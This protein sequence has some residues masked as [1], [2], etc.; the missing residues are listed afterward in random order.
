ME[1]CFNSFVR[2]NV[3]VPGDYRYR[4]FG[5]VPSGS[6]WTSLVGTV[7]NM[8]ML[9]L[10]S[11]EILREKGFDLR[12]MELGS[13]FHL[14]YIADVGGDDFAI[15]H[16]ASR[17]FL[18]LFAPSESMGRVLS[19]AFFEECPRLR[20][21]DPND[22]RWSVSRGPSGPAKLLR[23]PLDFTGESDL[24][25]KGGGSGKTLGLCQLAVEFFGMQIKDVSI[26]PYNISFYKGILSSRSE[27]WVRG[28]EI[29]KR[30]IA[31]ENPF[32]PED[33]F[34]QLLA[35]IHNPV[36]REPELEL[37][38]YLVATVAVPPVWDELLDL[39]PSGTK[40]LEWSYWHREVRRMVESRFHELMLAPCGHEWNF[41]DSDKTIGGSIPDRYS[42]RD[43]VRWSLWYFR[44]T[45]SYL[46]RYRPLGKRV[47]RKRALLRLRN[48]FDRWA[49]STN[50]LRRLRLTKASRPA[51]GL[52][53]RAVPSKYC[54][55]SA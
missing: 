42:R 55:V 37:V 7:S 1:W 14:G 33:W 21:K 50:W 43:R 48:S 19:S 45:Y 18:G 54:I 2:V 35:H 29:V 44:T 15:T 9:D 10:M 24:L 13:K 3:D 52:S 23:S 12:R 51:Q 31:P 39:G 17:R 22:P 26:H 49:G 4:I 47:K 5:G 38:A 8:I 30:L 46:P 53:L 6:P 36:N 16:S 28:R 11:D 32:N 25:V 40:A 20:P 41:P 27:F 34:A